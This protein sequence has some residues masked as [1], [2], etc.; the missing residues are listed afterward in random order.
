VGFA[1]VLAAAIL[2]STK[3]I[4]VK[5]AYPYASRAAKRLRSR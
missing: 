1:L 2:S 5:L 4:F 3:A